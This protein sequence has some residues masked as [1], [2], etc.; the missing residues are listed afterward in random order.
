MIN[1]DQFLLSFNTYKRGIVQV[2]VDG[3]VGKTAA[4]CSGGPRS[5][6]GPGRTYKKPNI[7]CMKINRAHFFSNRL[8]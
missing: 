3:A 8:I 2:V 6:T 1:A 5:I 4:C 7:N